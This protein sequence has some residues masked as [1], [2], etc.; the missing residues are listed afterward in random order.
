MQTISAPVDYRYTHR[1]LIM[2]FAFAQAYDVECEGRYETGITTIKIWTQPWT[3]EGPQPG[4]ERMGT[5]YFVWGHEN[6]L[7]QIVGEKGFTLADLLRELGILEEQALG[8]VR[9]GSDREER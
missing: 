8:K 4:S 7:W 2:L 1:E 5:F 3:P 6:R 9:Y